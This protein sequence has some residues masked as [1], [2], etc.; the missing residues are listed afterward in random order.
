MVDLAVHEAVGSAAEGVEHPGHAADIE[1]MGCC[2]EL[3]NAV[4]VDAADLHYRRRRSAE[5]SY[6]DSMRRMITM[7]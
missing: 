6:S 1:A 2:F 5:G 7:G 4:D 3:A